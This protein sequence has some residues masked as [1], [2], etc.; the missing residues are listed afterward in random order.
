MQGYRI[1]SETST[2]PPRGGA[3]TTATHTRKTKSH[4]LQELSI[5]T[6]ILIV[7]NGR[8]PEANALVMAPATLR[9]LRAVD[10]GFLIAETEL[11]WPLFFTVLPQLT[12]I[13]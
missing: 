8:M 12:H 9:R 2:P 5:G 13:Q 6:Q 3:T 11:E 7:P 10:F 1:C 4:V